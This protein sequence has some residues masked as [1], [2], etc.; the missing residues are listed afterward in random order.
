NLTNYRETPV[1]RVEELIRREAQRYGVTIHH[2][3]LVGLIPEDALVDAAV[4]YLQLDQFEPEQILEKRLYSAVQE[5]TESSETDATVPDFLDQLAEG[6][7]APG[8]G[9]AA[10]YTGAAAA[11]LVAMVTRLTIGK[12]KYAAVEDRMKQILTRAE[13]LRASL[14]GAVDRDSAAFMAVIDAF[15]LPKDT[16][17]QQQERQQAIEAATWDAARE[18]MEVARAAVELLGLAKETASQGNQNAICDSGT[19]AALAQAALTGAALNVRTNLNSLAGKDGVDTMLGDLQK[20][21]VQAAEIEK[22][23]RGILSERGGLSLP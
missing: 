5:K 22:E 1:A 11:A 17:I 13:E 16:P 4:W 21:E 19:S 7:P 14:T 8:G 23:I 9:S 12:K 18:P 6:S 10:A 3:E 15:R 20:L 2:S